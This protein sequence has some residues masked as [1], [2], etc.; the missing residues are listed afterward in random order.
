MLCVPHNTKEVR[1]AYKTKHDLSRENKVS[2]LM[3]TDG[4]KCHYLTVK[5]LLRGIKSKRD[6][7]FYC[8]N[9]LHSYS[10]RD[11]LKKHEN[12]S[13][14]HN[15]CYVEML[16]IGNYDEGSNKGYI[17]EVDIVYLKDLHDLLSDLPFL[18]KRIKINNCDKLVCNLYDKKT[19][20]LI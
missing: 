17:L 19:M 14:D 8:L 3:I 10:T 4:K 13:R 5:S 6:G 11:R 15:Y 9:C 2:L 12:V 20:L 16:D 1:H 18:T 7:G